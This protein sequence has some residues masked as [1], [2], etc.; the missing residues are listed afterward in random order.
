MAEIAVGES[1]EQDSSKQD[2]AS[3]CIARAIEALAGLAAGDACG[4]CFLAPQNR[5]PER[6]ASRVLPP[7]PW[8]FTDDTMMAVSVCAC[9]K[10][11]RGIEPEWLAE[12]FAR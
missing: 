9:L 4:E 1:G 7:P 2:A 12:S 3:A 6:R 5:A 11:H 10:R 8:R